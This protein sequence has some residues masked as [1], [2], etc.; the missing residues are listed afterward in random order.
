LGGSLAKLEHKI[1]SI[2]RRLDGLK[3][4]LETTDESS[5]LRIGRGLTPPSRS[6]RRDENTLHGE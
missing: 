5:I 6:L 1:V 3:E 4:A 2:E